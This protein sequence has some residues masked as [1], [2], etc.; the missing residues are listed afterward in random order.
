VPLDELHHSER[1]LI[2]ALNLADQTGAEIVVVTV[3]PGGRTGD[4]EREL[5]PAL[6]RSGAASARVEV[7]E[8]RAASTGIAACAAE[9]PDP[10]I[11][12]A[13]HARTRGGVLILGS[14]AEELIRATD[15]PIVFVGPEVPA[16]LRHRY[17]DL[18]VCLDGSHA[19]DAV[20]PTVAALASEAGLAPWLVQVVD[21]DWS[22]PEAATG[23]DVGESFALRSRA[24]EL[25]RAGLEPNWETLHGPDAAAAIDDFARSRRDA[26]IAMTT[27]G[28]SGLSRVTAGSVTISVIRHAAVPVLVTR[29]HGLD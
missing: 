29:S 3:R 9:Q 25:R 7:V 4:E 17:E 22:G 5:E 12:M 21:P 14:V 28:R 18:V 26:M 20:L 8:A 24:A 19:A 10:I 2:P 15:V 1:A 27:H 11:C 23:D 16:E 13:T 6:I